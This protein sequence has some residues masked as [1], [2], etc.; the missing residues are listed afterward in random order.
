MNEVDEE[1][2]QEQITLMN[3]VNEA[4]NQELISLELLKTSKDLEQTKLESTNLENLKSNESN[5]K[6]RDNQIKQ[7]LNNQKLP[8]PYIKN[9][10]KWI[11]NDKKAS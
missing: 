9:L 10:R 7:Y 2:N 1:E 3:V 4:E 6:D 8:L 11:S 5:S